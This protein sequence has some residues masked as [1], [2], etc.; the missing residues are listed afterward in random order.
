MYQASIKDMAVYFQRAL[1]TG[2]C[3][4][5]DV[6]S[7]AEQT[8]GKYSGD[9]PQWLRDLSAQPSAMEQR[10]LEAVPGESN[11]ELVWQL[12]FANLG[13][14]LRNR[15]FTHGQVVYLLVSWAAAGSMPE[16]Y[17]RMAYLFD[18]HHEGIAPGWFAEE[19]LKKEMAAF[20]E[21]FRPYE[22]LLPASP[23]T[24]RL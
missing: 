8:A 4:E 24:G 3:R 12:M 6:R 5:S 7:W 9:V 21:Q 2:L 1:A 11:D 10:L 13:R 16:E 20:F 17:R 23:Q 18:D 19:E 14:S 22:E 15:G